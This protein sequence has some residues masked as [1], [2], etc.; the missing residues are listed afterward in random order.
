MD[1]S[2]IEPILANAQ[3]RS[4]HTAKFRYDGRQGHLGS[5]LEVSV[6]VVEAAASD[7]GLAEE[8]VSEVVPGAE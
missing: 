2:S 4:F 5:W 7:R 6:A 8:Y 3:L 1:F